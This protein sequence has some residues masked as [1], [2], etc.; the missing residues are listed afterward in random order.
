MPITTN[1][2]LNIS[3]FFCGYQEKCG[4]IY[5]SPGGQ[6]VEG[7]NQEKWQKKG[8]TDGLKIIRHHFPDLEATLLQEAFHGAGVALPVIGGKTAF[9]M[10]VRL[11]S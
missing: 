6:R 3:R 7:G 4:Q 11:E 2:L 10:D 5:P 8:K 9:L 1:S